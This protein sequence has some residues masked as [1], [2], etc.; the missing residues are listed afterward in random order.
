MLLRRISMKKKVL[1][2]KV[3]EHA[4]F[5]RITSLACV[6]IIAFL[7]G[8]CAG[9][10]KMQAPA[11]VEPEPSE[12][13][14]DQTIECRKRAVTGSRFKRK[15]CKT[16]A[17]WARED[18]AGNKAAGELQKQADKSYSTNTGAPPKGTFPGAGPQ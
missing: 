3:K 1:F 2:T 13:I 15:I 12:I 8:A 14:G 18:S 16:K 5:I 4:S 6:L 9:E 11:K 7:T 10:K 17:Q